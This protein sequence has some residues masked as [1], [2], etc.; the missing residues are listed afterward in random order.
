MMASAPCGPT[1]DL[2]SEIGPLGF[3]PVA[4]RNLSQLIGTL[5]ENG[6]PFSINT[7]SVLLREN[8]RPVSLEPGCAVAAGEADGESSVMQTTATIAAVAVI[9]A[10]ATSFMLVN[11]R[12]VLL[13]CR[14]SSW[15]K[16]CAAGV[17]NPLQASNSC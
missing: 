4:T 12:I 9:A 14:T 5:N 16:R 11:L 3:L 7:V 15:R 13:L 10:L 6:T 1:T 2:L 8:G 17:S